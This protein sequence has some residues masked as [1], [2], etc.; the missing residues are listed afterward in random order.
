[1]IVYNYVHTIFSSL[2]ELFGVLT[3]AWFIMKVP[4]VQNARTRVD[5]V[6]NSITVLSVIF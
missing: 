5:N 6:L 3:A 1:M 2:H 4:S